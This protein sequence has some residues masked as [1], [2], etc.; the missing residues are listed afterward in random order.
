[1]LLRPFFA[2][3]PYT[4]PHG[5]FDIPDEDP[6]WSLYK[7]KPWPE[8]ARRYAAMVT[9]LD[10]QVGEVLALL[11]RTGNRRQ[12]AL[13]FFSGDNGGADYFSS[14]RVSPGDPWRKQASGNRH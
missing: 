4:P 9:M 10:R 5:L 11:R 7:D 8:Q 14:S 1:M 6:A 12:D 3:L 2:Y 13:V